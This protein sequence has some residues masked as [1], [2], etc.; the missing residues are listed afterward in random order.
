M[1]PDPEE[2]AR[3]LTPQQRL[4]LMSL[5]ANRDWTFLPIKRRPKV[6]HPIIERWNRPYRGFQYR[7]TPLGLAIRHILEQEAR[8]G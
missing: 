5:P 4:E 8:G 6:C 1:T 3:G 2:I 7:L